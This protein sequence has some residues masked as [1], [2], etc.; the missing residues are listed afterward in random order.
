MSAW[1]QGYR[2]PPLQENHRRL[3]VEIVRYQL[4]NNGATPSPRHLMGACSFAAASSVSTAIGGMVTRGLLE[5]SSHG[6]LIL[7]AEGR[8][9]IADAF[10]KRVRAAMS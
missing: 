7:T 8:E 10:D 6:Q 2:K 4:A 3:L 9:E 1:I 5:R